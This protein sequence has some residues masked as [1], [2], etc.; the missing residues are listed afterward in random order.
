M[1]KLLAIALIF[2]LAKLFSLAIPAYSQVAP[3]C[4]MRDGIAKALKDKYHE[5]SYSMAMGGTNSVVEVFRTKSG[6]TWSL[7]VTD[8]NTNQACVWGAGKHWKDLEPEIEGD[9]T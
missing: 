6:S 2:F 7:V 9:P 1:K 3:V 5:S 4:G 8:K